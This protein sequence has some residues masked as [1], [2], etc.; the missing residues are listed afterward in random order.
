M[1]HNYEQK[2]KER[3]F[4]RNKKSGFATTK[5]GSLIRKQIPIKTNQWDERKPGFIEADTVAHCGGSVSGQ[6][7]YYC[8]YC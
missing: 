6:F 3:I 8:Q 4:G 5:P 7:V 2:S 1:R